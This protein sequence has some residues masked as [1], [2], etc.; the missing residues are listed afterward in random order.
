MK[1]KYSKNSGNVIESPKSYYAVSDSL[2]PDV[3]FLP[4]EVRIFS[5]ATCSHEMAMNERVLSC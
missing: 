2:R 5:K 3:W 1:E 4:L